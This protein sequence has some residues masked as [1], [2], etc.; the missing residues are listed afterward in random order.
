MTSTPGNNNSGETTD[1]SQ[2]EGNE[3]DIPTQNNI[4]QQVMLE[5]TNGKYAGRINGTEGNLLV[6]LYLSET[7]ESIGL[8]KWNANSYE[9][10][11]SDNVSNVVGVIPGKDKTKAI[12]ITAHT[13]RMRQVLHNSRK[14]S[15]SVDVIGE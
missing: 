8:S 5:L 3:N 15:V 1:V 2:E 14:T 4:V 11:Y 9:H 13:R 6:T 12:V 7:F 10:P